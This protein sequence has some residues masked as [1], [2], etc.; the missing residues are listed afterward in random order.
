MCLGHSIEHEIL[1]L[2][3]ASY[4]FGPNVHEFPAVHL[5]QQKF[6]T[7]YNALLPTSGIGTYYQELIWIPPSLFINGFLP[8]VECLVVVYTDNKNL[9]EDATM[10]QRDLDVFVKWCKYSKL[11]I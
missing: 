11:C 2:K 1:L 4:G 5:Y 8:R 7:T 3:I 10:L 9:C 6:Y